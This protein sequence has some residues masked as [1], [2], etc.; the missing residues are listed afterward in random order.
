M[1]AGD[2]YVEPDPY[3]RAPRTQHLFHD[4]ALAL[5]VDRHRALGVGRTGV[6]LDNLRHQS[7]YRCEAESFDVKGNSRLHVSQSLQVGVAL[8]HYDAV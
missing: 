8:S 5:P 1:A 6:T 7:S 2:N 4:Q 3:G